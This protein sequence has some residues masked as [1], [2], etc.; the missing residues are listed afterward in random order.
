M[1]NRYVL[2]E[3]GT[4]YIEIGTCYIEIG[5]CYIEGVTTQQF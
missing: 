2:I 5:T 1:S 3:I 4:R